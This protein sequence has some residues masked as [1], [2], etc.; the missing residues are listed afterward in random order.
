[1]NEHNK[2]FSVIGWIL[3][4]VIMLAGIY[5]ISGTI[6]YINN[7]FLSLLIIILGVP[8][9]PALASVL[10]GERIN[11]KKSALYSAVIF[12]L[13]HLSDFIINLI[14]VL[15]TIISVFIDLFTIV[16][17]ALFALG[18]FA[19][20]IWLLN[21]IFNIEVLNGGILKKD[22]CFILIFD[23]ISFITLF[24]SLVIIKPLKKKYD[25]NLIIIN[26]KLYRYINQKIRNI[27][28]L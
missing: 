14:F 12:Y 7:I 22:L 10:Q 4:I 25:A 17:S 16:I 18:M 15:L 20:L 23:G 5:F 9:I 8:L 24:I 28:L 19:L 26:K 13:Y 11:S 3:S 21:Y 6:K 1:M 27:F 2:L